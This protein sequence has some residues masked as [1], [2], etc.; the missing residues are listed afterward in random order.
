MIPG[1]LKLF[2]LQLTCLTLFDLSKELA[3]QYDS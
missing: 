1:E 2:A 3:T